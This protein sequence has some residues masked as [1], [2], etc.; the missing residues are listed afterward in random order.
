MNGPN[1]QA[2]FAATETLDRLSDMLASAFAQIGESNVVG[3]DTLLADLGKKAI[4][5]R[6]LIQMVQ[7]RLMVYCK[8]L[9]EG[10]DQQEALRR[11]LLMPNGNNG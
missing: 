11:M 3:L 5:T 4:E 2:V 9:T 10:E 8:A 6:L 1:P 7:T